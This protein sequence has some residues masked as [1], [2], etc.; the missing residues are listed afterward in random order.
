[1]VKEINQ[2]KMI[3]GSPGH[4]WVYKTEEEIDEKIDERWM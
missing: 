1:M 4:A 3:D 2:H